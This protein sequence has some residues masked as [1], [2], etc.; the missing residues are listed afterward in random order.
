MLKVDNESPLIKLHDFSCYYSPDKY[1]VNKAHL[2]ISKGDIIGIT[3]ASGEGKS[4]LLRCLAGYHPLSRPAQEGKLDR[5]ELKQRDMALIF[6]HADSH[7]NPIRKIGAQL[8]DL[9]GYRSKPEWISLLEN[10]GLKPGTDF[11]EKY[12]FMNSGG[13]NQRIGWMMSL[14]QNPTLI[15]ADEP[16]SNLDDDLK[17]FFAQMLKEY[18]KLKNAAALVV[19]HDTAWLRQFVHG[20][21]VLQEG[22]LSKE[23]KNISG[24]SANLKYTKAGKST[25]VKL[26]DLSF[27][28]PGQNKD[29][30]KNL[31]LDVP[32]GAI[33]GIYGDSGQGKTT[34]LK[35]LAGDIH[36]SD[37]VNWD[38]KENKFYRKAFLIGQD[39]TEEFH[40]LYSIQS[41]FYEFAQKNKIAEGRWMSWVDGFGID[42][43]LLHQKPQA[44]S[45]GQVQRCA[46]IKA[47]LSRPQL[48][49]MD[50]SFS[51]LDDPNFYSV[52]KQLHELIKNE[53]IAVIIVMHRK[54]LL[55]SVSHQCFELINGQ[56]YHADQS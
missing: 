32:A 40:P 4:T 1:L 36:V 54:D 29:L 23:E 2:Q 50:E 28:Y 30:L 7:L 53:N 37:A 22:Q 20:L 52:S 15:L 16:V 34:L 12:P 45:G 18:V 11:Y 56:L 24:P 42:H 25:V 9:P 47:L 51:G 33:T 48:L 38:I 39:P 13:Q 55:K 21:Y 41:Q 10:Y 8:N 6:Q 27:R 31:N 17:S 5:Y 46:I 26:S 44:L 19:S 14:S 43:S 35:I 49:L 3:G